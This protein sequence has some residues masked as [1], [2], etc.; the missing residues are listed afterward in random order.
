MAMKKFM[1]S[2]R[3]TLIRVSEFI[4]FF[5]FGS[6]LLYSPSHLAK[7]VEKYLTDDMFVLSCVCLLGMSILAWLYRE[8][9]L[10]NYLYVLMGFFIPLINECLDQ[11]YVLGQNM[12]IIVF[13]FIV[14]KLFYKAWDTLFEIV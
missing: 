1:K 5:A 10:R 12:I 4:L 14:S 11:A 8:I 13:V 6:A 7:A 9:K 3:I 2:T